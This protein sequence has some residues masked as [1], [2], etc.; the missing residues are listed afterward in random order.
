LKSGLCAAACLTGGEP[1]Q[2]DRTGCCLRVSCCRVLRAAMAGKCAVWPEADAG[3]TP[4]G[5]TAFAFFDR[6]ARF[7]RSLQSASREPCRMF[8]R[9]VSV[10]GAERPS[11]LCVLINPILPR[12]IH[13]DQAGENLEILL[14][15]PETIPSCSLA[16]H[17]T[18]SF[19]APPSRMGSRRVS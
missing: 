13:R 14:L 16:A 3:K 4:V 9:P 15:R 7:A 18:Q 10:V 19:R 8:R 5:R 11:R 2:K 12:A 1:G 17:T 6:F